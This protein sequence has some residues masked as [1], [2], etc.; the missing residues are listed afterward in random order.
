[1]TTYRIKKNVPIKLQ[2]LKHTNTGINTQIKKYEK[3]DGIIKE[4]YKNLNFCTNNVLIEFPDGFS[5]WVSHLDLMDIGVGITLNYSKI[6]KIIK[7]CNPDAE[8]PQK[9][10]LNIY[11]EFL[12][13]IYEKDIAKKYNIDIYII[14]EI[15]FLLK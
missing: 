6:L 8:N 13:G 7:Q 1:M 15:Y 11:Y 5:C 3:K 10:L 9:V 14:A 12:K 2:R 4:D